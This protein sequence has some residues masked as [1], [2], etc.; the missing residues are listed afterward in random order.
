MGF[1]P[2]RKDS[3]SPVVVGR[4]SAR[5]SMVVPITIK[6]TDFNEQVFKENTWTIGVNKHGAKVATFR[7][8][9][10]G[11]Q[12]L[13][14]NPILG[15]TALATVIRVGEKR[16]PEDPY[17]IGVELVEA[18]NVWGVKFPPED[19]QKAGAAPAGG[20]SRGSAS[21]PA[22]SPS[23]QPP[24]DAL[25]ASA[26]AQAPPDALAEVA[27]EAATPAEPETQPSEPG[28]KFNQFNLA[29]TALSR[30]AEQAED[31][32]AELRPEPV[33]KNEKPDDLLG[34]Q[35]P[36]IPKDQVQD[37]EGKIKSMTAL[38]HELHGLTHRLETS[39]K[40]FEALLSRAEARQKSLSPEVTRPKPSMSS[41]KTDLANGE[42]E[43]FRKQLEEVSTAAFQ[44]FRNRADIYLTD[45]KLKLKDGSPAREETRTEAESV[46]KD[47]DEISARALAQIRSLSEQ[48]VK[49]ASDAIYKHVGMG[50]V[51]LK[52]WAE[53]ASARLEAR[54]QNSLEAFQKEMSSLAKSA[55]EEQ[56][57]DSE[58]FSRSLQ[59]RLQ[60]AARRLG[61]SP[62]E[63]APTETE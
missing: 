17:E 44:Q 57:R 25:A 56:R 59:S 34:L 26:L 40:E 6:G 33:E 53:Q 63:D 43:N 1:T 19:W 62:A 24:L 51:V 9:A 4:R 8:L 38:V 29:V 49:E 15:R 22:S 60:Q 16:F 23:A 2:E 37:V 12:V 50:A 58:T 36:P 3:N 30:Y 48:A 55:L 13:I 41:P 47:V 32:T 5:L 54:F 46:K 39:R 10:L 61:D 28:E 27:D 52:D 31:K 14:E 11:S 35:R 42:L 18:Q 7:Q 20:R 45:R 21:S